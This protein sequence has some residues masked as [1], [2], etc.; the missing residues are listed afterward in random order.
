[1]PD[2]VQRPDGALV[3][4]FTASLLEG[5]ELNLPEGWQVYGYYGL[6]HGRRAGYRADSGTWI[7]FGAPTGSTL[8]NRMV[9]QTTV[10]FRR[11]FW[12]AEG[13][14]ALSYA[15]NYSYLSRKLWELT[16]SGDRGRTHML[17]TSFRYNLP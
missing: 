5:L 17:Y 2:L 7:G 9:S 16:S 14:G 6:V 3:P 12:Q 13:R 1:M 10:G 11:T 4:V 15:V 8:D